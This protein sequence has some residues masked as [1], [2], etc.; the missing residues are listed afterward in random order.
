MSPEWKQAYNKLMEVYSEFEAH[1]AAKDV[2]RI[3]ATKKEREE[4]ARTY[5][6]RIARDRERYKT[7]S[8]KEL[9]KLYRDWHLAAYADDRAAKI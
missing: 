7:S 6:L 2:R 1:N 4:I 5:A 9:K 3:R 8:T